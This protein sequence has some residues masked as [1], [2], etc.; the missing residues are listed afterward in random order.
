[1]KLTKKRAKA[2]SLEVWRCLRDNPAMMT[3][4]DLPKRIYSKIKD[5]DYECPL[6]NLPDHFLCSGYGMSQPNG[7]PLYPLRRNQYCA[8]G[9]YKKWRNEKKQSQRKIHAAAIVKLIEAWEV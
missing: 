3:K 9:H 1:M 2:I 5:M 6:C 7:C 4:S 8:C